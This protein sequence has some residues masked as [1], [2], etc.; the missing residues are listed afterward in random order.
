MFEMNRGNDNTNVP[1]TFKY[2][3]P[4]TNTVKHQQEQNLLS[5]LILY[6]LNEPRYF[7]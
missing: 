1:E 3:F 2:D 6:W 5:F 7:E 4:E